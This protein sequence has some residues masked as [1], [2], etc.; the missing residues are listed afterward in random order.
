MKTEEQK[1]IDRIRRAA[2]AMGK[3]SALKSP[4]SREFLSEIG[5]KGSSVR[6]GKK[7]LVDK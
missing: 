6:W 5:R 1:Q 2:S 7:D 3:L 4:K